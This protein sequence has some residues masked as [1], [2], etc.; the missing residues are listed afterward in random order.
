MVA[1]K[2]VVVGGGVAGLEALLT[3]RDLAEERADLTLVA[4]VPEFVY[5]PDYKAVVTPDATG[6]FG[7]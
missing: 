1:M 6:A 4:P 2:V 7:R 3:L 5:R